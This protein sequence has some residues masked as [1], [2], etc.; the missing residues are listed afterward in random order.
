MKR[1]IKIKK[2]GMRKPGKAAF[3]IL[4]ELNNIIRPGVSG[5]DINAFIENF[6]LEH[7]PGYNL[8]SKGYNGFPA[9]ACISVNECIVHGIP[10]DCRFKNGDLVKVDIVVEY[11]GWYADTAATYIVGKSGADEKRLV[12]ITREALYE[13]IKTAMPGNTTGDIGYA[14]QNYIKKEGFSVMRDYCGHGIGRQMHM[15][16]QVPN[17]GRRGEGAVLKEGMAIAIEPMVLMGKPDVEVA[18]NGWAVS[19]KDRLMTAHFE[20]TVLITKKKPVII[21]G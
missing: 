14:V 15:K 12:N 13:G 6:I 16:P 10:S 17:Y 1:E 11:N 8:S 18:S 9:S 19:S 2:K 21:T 7:Y 20:H 4:S 3:K 5:N